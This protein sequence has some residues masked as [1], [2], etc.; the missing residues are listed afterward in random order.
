MPALGTLCSFARQYG[1]SA[2]HGSLTHSVCPV[3][4]CC[5]V[6]RGSFF[7]A[8][9]LVTA[10]IETAEVT[11]FALLLYFMFGFQA[12]A[13]KFLIWWLTLVLFALASETLGMLCA[14]VTPDSKI[15]VTVLSA[16]LVFL[17]SFSGF[18]V[19][20]G[21]GSQPWCCLGMIRADYGS[22]MAV[23]GV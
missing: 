3:L 18:L 11:V 21:G 2:S 6:F 7:A 14:I 1:S 5:H 22:I 15:G 12:T 17:L 9:S 19:S 16:V 4:Y 10:P 8:K 23:V 13:A 20:A